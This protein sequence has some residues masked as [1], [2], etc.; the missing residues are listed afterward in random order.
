M[1]ALCTLQIILPTVDASDA[2]EEGWRPIRP[3][4]SLGLVT[5]ILATRLILPL[6]AR[7]AGCLH[8]IVPVR[9]SLGV[10]RRRAL[11]L[12]T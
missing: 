7:V 4:K 12:G 1:H 11:R 9:Y 5:E 6:I 3:D 10:P 8:R 2:D